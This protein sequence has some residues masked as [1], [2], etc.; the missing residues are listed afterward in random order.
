M[1]PIQVASDTI[2]IAAKAAYA[3]MIEIAPKYCSALDRYVPWEE[4]LEERRND[5][6]A[7]IAAA[8]TAALPF[9]RTVTYESDVS[10]PLAATISLEAM[11]AKCEAIV[12]GFTLE[13]NQGRN[14]FQV[15]DDWKDGRTPS[16]IYNLGAD[17]AAT[18]I[19][20]DIAALKE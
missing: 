19:A 10:N 4:I 9:L 20:A 12:R 18:F 16:D 7:T 3:K 15:P 8:L 13:A 2:E 6:K 17:D 5:Y 11:R 1:T 14:R